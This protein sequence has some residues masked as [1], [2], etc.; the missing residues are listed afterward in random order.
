MREGMR[1]KDF[2][3]LEREMTSRDPTAS[4]VRVYDNCDWTYLCLSSRR[5]PGRI[6]MIKYEDQGWETM[7]ITL[8]LFDEGDISFH[9]EAMASY[10]AGYSMRTEGLT[11][12]GPRRRDLEQIADAAVALLSKEPLIKDGS[13]L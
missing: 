3:A 9:P 6:V 10:T 11:V 7:V 8:D 2:V 13:T 4:L 12:R 1:E 5:V